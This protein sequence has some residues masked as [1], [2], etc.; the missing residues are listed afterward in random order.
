MTP[1]ETLFLSRYEY[2]LSGGPAIGFSDAHRLYAW[3]LTRLPEEEAE[4]LHESGDP[5]V[6]QH[7]RKEYGTGKTI[8]SVNIL[9]QEANEVISPALEA[10]MEI[11]LHPE[12][13][14]ATLVRQ[15][16]FQYQV[17][18]IRH[19]REHAIDRVAE[20]SLLS[21]MAFHQAGHYVIY[22][23]EQLLLRSLVKK[24]NVAFNGGAGKRN[25]D[26]R[27]SAA[28]GAICVKGKQNSRMS[29]KALSAVPPSGTAF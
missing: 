17:D 23:Q 16:G 22:P 6:S 10:E 20:V 13:L 26:P 21:P 2:E 24:W 1:C 18:F 12:T 3:L 15:N 27:L 8:W 29:R 28:N 14:K 11:G 25:L 9:S 4:W 19:A 7:I 5:P